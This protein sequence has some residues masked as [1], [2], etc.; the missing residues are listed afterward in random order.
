MEWRVVKSIPLREVQTRIAIFNEK[1]GSLSLLH[2]EFT[3]GRMPPGVFDEYIEW[4]NMDHAVRAYQEGEDFE[5]LAE[6]DM[7]LDSKQY[8]K[9]TPRRLELLD[10]LGMGQYSSINELA[11]QIGR[12][13]KNVYNDLKTL[14]ELGFVSLVKEGRSTTPE[15]IV[16]EINILLG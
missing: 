13:V 11:D 4:T 5:Y 10:F 14:E 2:E 16:H 15:L 8:E 7:S 9:L 12:D 3:K 1:Y 6:E